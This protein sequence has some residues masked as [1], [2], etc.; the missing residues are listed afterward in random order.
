VAIIGIRTPV[1][2]SQ[3]RPDLGNMPTTQLR[4]LHEIKINDFFNEKS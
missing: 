1:I 2:W 4:A 3:V